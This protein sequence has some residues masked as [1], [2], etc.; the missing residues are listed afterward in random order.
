MEAY[1]KEV[2]LKQILHHLIVRCIM[3][4]LPGDVFATNMSG[5]FVTKQPLPTYLEQ[6][7]IHNL[8]QL[9]N[10]PLIVNNHQILLEQAKTTSKAQFHAYKDSNEYAYS[11][12]LPIRLLQKQPALFVHCI[13]R[14]KKPELLLK[15]TQRNIK[16]LQA[17]YTRFSCQVDKDLRV[18]NHDANFLEACNDHR[19]ST[20]NIINELLENLLPAKLADTFYTELNLAMTAD[21]STAKLVELEING[22]TRNYLTQ[23]IP[24]KDHSGIII[25][26]LCTGHLQSG[27]KLGA[28]IEND[29]NFD[30]LLANLPGHI[31]WKDLNGKILAC[32]HEQA[33][34]VG[35]KSADELYADKLESIIFAEKINPSELKQIEENDKLVIADKEA[36]MFEESITINKQTKTYLSKKSPLILDGQ[37]IG[38]AGV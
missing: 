23:F 32:N 3:K 31:Y 7:N 11:F 27:D 13:I 35:E 22:T 38:S 30:E 15:D 36:I 33:Q 9:P 12:C 29:N 24:I 25:G 34:S 19:L 26:S 28:P 16:N 5:D 6:N 37:C 20:N 10:D 17:K 21:V 2:K 14:K 18:L 8:S 4:V 1:W